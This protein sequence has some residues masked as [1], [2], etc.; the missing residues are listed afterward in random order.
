[1]GDMEGGLGF[2]IVWLNDLNALV[3]DGFTDGDVIR[4]GEVGSVVNALPGD[5]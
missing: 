3:T 1:M 2:T 5:T 4:T